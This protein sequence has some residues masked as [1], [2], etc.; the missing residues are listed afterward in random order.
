MKRLLAAAFCL[1]VLSAHDL[2]I[3][4]DSY[5]LPAGGKTVLKLYNGTF[6]KSENTITRDRIISP[7][8][9]GPGKDFIPV[10]KD[11][12]DEGETTGL[13]LSG[14]KA[15]THLAAV[16]TKPR[17]IDLS[18]QD[19]NEYLEHDGVKDMLEQRKRKGQLGLD[20]REKY[21]KHVKAI[22]QVG[23]SKTDHYKKVM[24]YPVE[25]VSMQNPY[26]LKVGDDLEVQLLENGRPL[27]KQLV[28]YHLRPAPGGQKAERSVRTDQNGMVKV[29]ITHPGIW[30]LRTIHMVEIDGEEYN[31]QSNWTTLTFEIK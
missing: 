10:S 5:I 29:K 15:G 4:M 12:Y 6:D 18:A 3:R 1:L 8:I 11:W 23:G 31:Y 19:F 16:S 2:F 20:A 26:L 17:M 27:Q 9:S 24:G 22:F 21:A 28:Y 13:K 7:V 14:L 25:F 30:Y